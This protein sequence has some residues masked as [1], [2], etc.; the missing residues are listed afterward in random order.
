MAG[1]Q[2]VFNLLRSSLDMEEVAEVGSY[3]RAVW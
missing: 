1:L 3:D 2:S